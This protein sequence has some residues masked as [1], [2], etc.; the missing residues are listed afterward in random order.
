LFVAALALTVLQGLTDTGSRPLPST[1][2]AAA[3]IAVIVPDGATWSMLDALNR[4]RGE[5]MSVGFEIRLVETRAGGTPEA[6]LTRVAREL[7]PAAVVALASGGQDREDAEAIRAVDVWFL[8]RTSGVISVGHLAIE[9]DAG[10]RAEQ[11]L[12]V[13]VVDFIRA[14]MFDSLVRASVGAEG[15][16]PRRAPPV[17]LGRYQVFAGL[18]AVGSPSGSTSALL[19]IVEAGFVLRPWLRLSLAGGG[20]GSHV[21]LRS[22]AGSVDIEQRLLRIGA[23]FVA[24]ALGRRWYLHAE[25]GLALLSVVAHGQGSS[26]YAGHVTSGTSPG[27][28][29]LG[30]IVLALTSHLVL[31]SS[32]GALW[33]LR[34]QQVFIADTQVA[35]TG[36]PTWLASV[37][38]GVTFP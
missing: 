18:A 29:G 33:L 4:L 9:D 16:R 35:R 7:S 22:E 26:G 15:E 37:M 24:P 31:Q 36:R 32:L 17:P 5:A 3:V 38:V 28:H 34:E 27:A 6:N 19:P 30:G 14:R 2:A 21:Q 25:T 20:L 10:R 23:T 1:G 13:S 12:A 8:D 11:A